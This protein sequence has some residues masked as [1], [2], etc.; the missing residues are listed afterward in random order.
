GPTLFV[1]FLLVPRRPELG[2]TLADPKTDDFL[3]A[4]LKADVENQEHGFT[5]HIQLHENEKI[6][7]LENT[8][9]EWKKESIPVAD[10]WIPVQPFDFEERVKFGEELSFSPWVCMVDHEP[11][12]AIN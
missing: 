6:E 11:V 12:G 5:L 10:L 1:K 7:P 9:K 4:Q 8:S 2:Y 3:K